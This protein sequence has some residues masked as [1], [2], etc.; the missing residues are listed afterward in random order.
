M[1]TNNFGT[2]L[3]TPTTKGSCGAVSWPPSIWRLL[4][5]SDNFLDKNQQQSI[6]MLAFCR[7]HGQL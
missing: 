1:D 6:F 3:V 2:G 5:I 7:M 4:V